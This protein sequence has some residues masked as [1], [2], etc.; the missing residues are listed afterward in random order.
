MRLGRGVE[1]GSP[2]SVG[3]S[4]QIR[5]ARSG[6]TESTWRASHSARVQFA[7]GPSQTVGRRIAEGVQEESVSVA[8]AEGKRRVMADERLIEL[9]EQST[10]PPRSIEWLR[11]A[12]RRL[13][14]APTSLSDIE[15]SPEGE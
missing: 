11:D 14:K 2:K 9:D 1:L 3:K 4:D 12:L 7:G 6:V 10:W 13:R 5:R 8:F 15:F